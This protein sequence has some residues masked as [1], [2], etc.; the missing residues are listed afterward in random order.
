MK[1]VFQYGPFHAAGMYAQGGPDVGFFGPAYGANVGGTYGGFSIDAVYQK[2]NAGVQ[3][4][5][6]TASP[7]AGVNSIDAPPANYSNTALNGLVTDNDSWSVQAK[8]IFTFEEGSKDGGLK[9]GGP[10]A[11]FWTGSR[12]TLFAGFE[13][14]RYYNSS[15][16]RD[17]E[18]VGQ[19]V[20]N[21]Y[22]HWLPSCHPWRKQ[23]I[24][25]LLLRQYK[26]TAA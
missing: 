1:Y 19:T 9:D 11:D 7:V 23:G 18:Y 16:D 15:A 20:A 22:A 8:Y 12:L 17:R 5:S 14:I 21:G 10:V 26:R 2:V 6:L 4:S 25:P 3:L 24:E 13:D